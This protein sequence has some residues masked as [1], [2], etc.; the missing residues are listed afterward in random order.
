VPSYTVLGLPSPEDESTKSLLISVT[1]YQPRKPEKS[2]LKC[3]ILNNNNITPL[4]FSPPNS[5][6]ISILLSSSHSF[7]VFAVSP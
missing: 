4:K 2:T 7:Y 3:Y 6:F 5:N 1:I